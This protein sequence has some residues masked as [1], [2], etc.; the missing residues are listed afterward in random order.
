MREK[1]GVYSLS[2]LSLLLWD[3]QK[4]GNRRLKRRER[5]KKESEKRQNGARDE[6]EKVQGQSSITSNV[7]LNQEEAE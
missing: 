4:E 1:C 2:L 7:S 3:T 5:R 6:R